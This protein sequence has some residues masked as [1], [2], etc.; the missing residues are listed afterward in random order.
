MKCPYCNKEMEKGAI[1]SQ[2]EIAWLKGDKRHLFAKAD[3]HEG[4]VVLSRLSII[5]GAAVTA[6]LC[7]DCRKVVIDYSDES[8]DWNAK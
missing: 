5:K 3:F 2:Q 7:R 1:Q 4:S 8:S 6:Y